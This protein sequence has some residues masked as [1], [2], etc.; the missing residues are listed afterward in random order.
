MSRPCVAISRPLFSELQ[1]RLF[2]LVVAAGI[3]LLALWR[4]DTGAATVEQAF[5]EAAFNVV[6]IIST[7][8][9]TSHDFNL[10]GG[11]PSLL[12]LCAM[13]MGGCTGSTAGGIK[14]FRLFVLLEALKAQIRRQMFPSGV[15]GAALQPPADRRRRSSPPS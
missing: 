3:V 1:V 8:G 9:F 4:L 7:T 5:R 15:F 10:W 12:L 11:F 6:S 14:M 2:L 13:L